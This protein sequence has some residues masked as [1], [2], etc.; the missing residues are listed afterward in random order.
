[1]REQGLIADR[2]A[3]PT[4]YYRAQLEA[5]LRNGET[6]LRDALVA[7]MRDSAP[8]PAD[9][10][11]LNR[12]LALREADR[13]QFFDRIG[14]RWDALREECFGATFHL[15]ALL[16]LLPADLV[17]ADLGTG[18]GYLL[19]ALARHFRRVI[20]VD[21]SP[22]M[23][24]LAGRRV[25]EERLGNVELRAGQVESLP[26]ADGEVD[27]VLAL[28]ILHHVADLPT[29]LTDI[30]RALKPGGTLLVVDLHP[31]GNE[32]FRVQM[33]DRKS[34]VDR[35]EMLRA[36]AHAG[37]EETG[38]WDIPRP[39]R[40]DHALAPLPQLYCV[41]AKRRATLPDFQFST[42]QP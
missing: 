8:S 16:H 42:H 38:H 19:P 17:V 34:G 27:L 2:P 3:G 9:R 4:T 23:L 12:V 40:P 22:P 1:M 20:A 39:E 11:R 5:D 32:A 26:L 6:P 30:A 29:T 33:A 15:E 10:D 18:T 36:L 35:A 24:E 21:S 25:A 13:E 28:L 7:L 41:A 14:L 37:F 31:H